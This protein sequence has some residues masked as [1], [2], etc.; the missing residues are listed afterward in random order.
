MENRAFA[1]QMTITV[2]QEYTE[3][4]LREAFYDFV[5]NTLGSTP[6]CHNAVYDNRVKELN[7]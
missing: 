4:S 6:G 5:K 1:I 3:D 7:D 2:N